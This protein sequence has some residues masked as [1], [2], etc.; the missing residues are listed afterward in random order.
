MTSF[1]VNEIHFSDAITNDRAK[2]KLKRIGIEGLRAKRRG[3]DGW[4]KYVL[5]ENVIGREL[6][7]PLGR[8]CKILISTTAPEEKEI[9]AREL[10][11]NT[12][13]SIS[14][15]WMRDLGVNQIGKGGA[16]KSSEEPY[17]NYVGYTR[18]KI[19]DPSV[20][21]HKY[22]TDIGPLLGVILSFRRAR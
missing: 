17:T 9:V 14:G 7:I 1:E 21:V 2:T 3:E 10:L 6:L 4:L 15:T 20:L 19:T 16:V 5:S 13:S 11:F 22:S 8:H 18:K 12:T